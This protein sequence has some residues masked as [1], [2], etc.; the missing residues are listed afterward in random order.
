MPRL[1]YED[2]TPGQV[3]VC[4]PRQVTRDEIVAFAAVYDPQPMHLDDAAAA[5]G[6]LGGLAASGWHTCA[7]MM[8][9]L[10]DGYVFE[11]ASMGSP[12]NDEIRWLAPVRPGDT[13]IVNAHV[14]ERRVSA[15]RP[16]MGLVK[17]RYDTLNQHGECVMSVTST[18]LAERRA[19]AEVRA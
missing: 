5:A 6:M 19:T 17:M 10:Y 14:L 16:Q 3:I 12:G 8:R 2:F 18:M 1:Y 4:G 13:L 9:M 15:S 7:L 11:T